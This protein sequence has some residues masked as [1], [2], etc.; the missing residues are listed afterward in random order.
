MQTMTRSATQS[1]VIASRLLDA[2]SRRDYILLGRQLERAAGSFSNEF[3]LS[4]RESEALE[5]LQGVAS[6]LSLMMPRLAQAPEVDIPELDGP[7][8]LLETL[9]N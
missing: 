9:A 8:T 7:A 5:A 1:S 4:T 6:L 2:L 3:P